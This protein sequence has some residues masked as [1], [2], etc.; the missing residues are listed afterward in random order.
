MG[1]PRFDPSIR[2]IVTSWTS[3]VREAA[4]TMSHVGDATPIPS[5][6]L[7]DT[8][9]RLMEA[10]IGG[11]VEGPPGTHTTPVPP[12]QPHSTSASNGADTPTIAIRIA[13]LLFHLPPPLTTTRP[14]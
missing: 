14:P 1:P 12:S 9:E 11:A 3:T 4:M 7:C 10:V 13:V 8:L 5:K 2:C 6:K